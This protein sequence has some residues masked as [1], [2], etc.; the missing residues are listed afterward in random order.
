MQFKICDYRR[1]GNSSVD[2]LLHECQCCYLNSRLSTSNSGLSPLG[3]SGYS[4]TSIACQYFQLNLT[5]GPQ[6]IIH[7][8]PGI[9]PIGVEGPVPLSLVKGLNQVCQSRTGLQPLP[10]YTRIHRLRSDWSEYCNA[11]SSPAPVASSAEDGLASIFRPLP[12][13]QS[14]SDRDKQ[15]VHC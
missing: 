14:A 15:T 7:T 2:D 10:G 13:I 9:F 12:T 1:Y 11:Y 8:G 3:F 6:F 5:D 4:P